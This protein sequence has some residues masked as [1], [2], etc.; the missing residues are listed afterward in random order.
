MPKNTH[1]ATL[2]LGKRHIL[3]CP[4]EGKPS[5]PPLTFEEG[6]PVPV[7]DATKARL[8]E[9]ATQS[10]TI[11]NAKG[12]YEGLNTRCKFTFEPIEDAA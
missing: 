11:R 12:G 4:D 7:T 1:I 10:H 8:E 3:M 2:V 5:D 6:K 9:F